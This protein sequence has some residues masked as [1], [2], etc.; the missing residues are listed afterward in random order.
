M[1]FLDKVG[2]GYFWEQIKAKIP[3]VIVLQSD[4]DR[5]ALINPVEKFYYV[6]EDESLWRFQGGEWVL[7]NGTSLFKRE[8]FTYD[9]E[10]N[11]FELQY[12]P[13]FVFGVY[14][15][16]QPTLWDVAGITAFPPL[17]EEYTIVDNILTITRTMNEGDEVV[18][19]YSV[20]N[21]ETVLEH[22]VDVRVGG[23]SVVGND[24]VARI[25]DII[26]DSEISSGYTWSSDNLNDKFN[27]IT[28]SDILTQWFTYQDTNVFVLDNPPKN[29]L[30]VYI[31][32]A[33]IFTAVFEY[34]VDGNTVIVSEAMSVGDTVRI[35]Y[36]V[37]EEGIVTV[38]NTVLDNKIDI[39]RP[40]R[41]YVYASGIQEN[42]AYTSDTFIA[43]FNVPI[44]MTITGGQMG[45]NL[46]QGMTI[47]NF[48]PTQSKNVD[49]SWFN[50]YDHPQYGRLFQ[51]VE[52]F[53]C[54]LNMDIRLSGTISGVGS[55]QTGDFLVS[56]IR[57][58]GGVMMVARDVGAPVAA[59]TTTL[60]AKG[61]VYPS[62][63]IS[64]TDPF[65]TDGLRWELNNPTQATITLSGMMTLLIVGHKC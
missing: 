6:I 58:D 57:P 8:S 46:I 23:V 22:V 60:N 52:V 44:S 20:G 1:S 65:V 62:Y 2:L 37:A 25:P 43:R 54:A 63:I 39:I 7:L 19:K 48:S 16:T 61:F 47:D 28:T 40:D 56:L 9:G 53:D 27:K 30:S 64:P 17:T 32:N 38:N 36:L 3:D 51:F 31:M 41:P 45:V 21:P 11:T 26:N 4:A 18:I 13:D 55:G 29:V 5:L 34:Q 24:M 35:Q 50:I 12:T 59:T 42:L 49:S 15:F 33:D 10:I 14:V